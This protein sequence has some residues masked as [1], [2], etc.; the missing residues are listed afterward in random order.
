MFLKSIA[1]GKSYKREEFF[2]MYICMNLKSLFSIPYH[3]WSFSVHRENKFG[4]HQNFDNLISV[5][6]HHRFGN[7]AIIYRIILIPSTEHGGQIA[8]VTRTLLQYYSWLTVLF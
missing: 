2:K 4:R 7:V 1:Y 6:M 3:L 5:F 8:T